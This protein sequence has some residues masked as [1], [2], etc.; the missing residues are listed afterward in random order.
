MNVRTHVHIE[1]ARP[2]DSAL[3]QPAAVYVGVSLKN[4]LTVDVNFSLT[5]KYTSDERN[6]SLRPFLYSSVA[7]AGG[8]IREFSK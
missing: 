7:P 2:A 6:E 4:T 5:G 3:Q 8:D 1:V